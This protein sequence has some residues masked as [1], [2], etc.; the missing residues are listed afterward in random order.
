MV[1][2]EAEPEQSFGCETRSLLV[3]R[4]DEL[5]RVKHLEVTGW[6]DEGEDT[7]E[8]LLPFLGRTSLSKI[9][10]YRRP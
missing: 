2:L 8:L 10:Q 4:R 5:F 3:Q 9:Q 1:S 7:T 6:P